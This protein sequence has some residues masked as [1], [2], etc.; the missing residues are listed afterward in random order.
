MDD[1]L[2]FKY[3]ITKADGSPVDENGA[4]FVLKL[5]SKDEAHARACRAGARAYAQAIQEAL[6]ELSLDLERKC[7]EIEGTELLPRRMRPFSREELQGI[8]FRAAYQFHT[9]AS[10]PRWGSV[11]EHLAASADHLDLMMA[12]EEHG[13]T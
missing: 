9:C 7:C 3:H 13:G 4:Y 8:Y 6:P 12:R 2:K 5:N 1:G 10:D 11:Y